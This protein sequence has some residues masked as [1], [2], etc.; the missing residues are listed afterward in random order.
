[1]LKFDVCV[2][3]AGPAGFAAA[4]RAWDYGKKVC[5]IDRAALGGTGVHNGALSSK[6]LWELSRDYRRVLRRDRGYTTGPIHIEYSQVC[7]AVAEAVAE[8][9]NQLA[10]QLK[11][12]AEPGVCQQ[13]LVTYLKGSA[14]FIDPHQVFVEGPEQVVRAENFVLATGSRPRSLP[15]IQIDGHHIVTSDHIMKIDRFPRSLVVL[16]AGVIGCEFA[17]IFANFGQTKVYLIDRADRILPFEDADIAQVCAKNLEARGVTIHHRSTLLEMK[18][19]DGE[20]HYTIQHATGGVETIVVEQALVSIGRVPNTSGMC[21]E[22]AGLQVNSRGYLEDED[23]RT[24]LP[25]IYAVGDVTQDIALVSIAEIEGR[26]AVE[27]MYGTVT[28]ALS[29]ENVSS[30]MFLDPEVAGVGL[31]E[32]QAQKTRTPYRVA[33]YDYSLVNR[34]IAMR[35]TG[36]FIKLLATDD[37][38]MR[39]LGIRALGAHASTSIETVSLMIRQGRSVRDLAELLHPHPAITEGLQDCV[40]M[41]LGSSIMKPQ[42]FRRKLRVSRIG[43]RTATGET[44]AKG[45][46][47]TKGETA[48]AKAAK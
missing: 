21:L 44:A 6:T 43:Y 30:I 17:T 34:A 36:G 3:G 23:T 4:M 40:R 39:I 38:E 15:D 16:G 9:T 48:A 1:M 27:H 31:N 42:V 41:L 20:V 37:D 8:K 12:L 32:I 14:E 26:H 25:H 45:G 47:A 22:K 13:A 2:I 29:Y 19:V 11:V 35:A 28:A 33:V 5:L 10:H 46:T 18:V 24:S 7:H